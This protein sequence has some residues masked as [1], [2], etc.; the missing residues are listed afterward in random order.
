M[1]IAAP[2]PPAVRLYEPI[3]L[4]FPE[5]AVMP[6]NTTVASPSCFYCEM[7]SPLPLAR[8][9]WISA[10]G[11]EALFSLCWSCATGTDAEI[12][13]RIIAKLRG[14]PPAPAMAAN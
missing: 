11:A 13:A 8:L 5:R 6:P 10:N 9:G 14:E 7:T 12:K 1:S 4:V 2:K 3:E